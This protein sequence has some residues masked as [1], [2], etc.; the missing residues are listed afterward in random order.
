M[1]N[2]FLEKLEAAL[3]CHQDEP[4]FRWAAFN[5]KKKKNLHPKLFVQSQRDRENFISCSLFVFVGES[6][7]Y[8][9]N[10]FD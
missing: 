2:T 7:F 1:Y 4:S 9:E 5:I 10:D 8:L 3:K 6:C